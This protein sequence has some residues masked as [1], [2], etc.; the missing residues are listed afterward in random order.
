MSKI[1]LVDVSFIYG[2]GTPFEMVA[3]DNVNVKFEK[4]KITC[5]R[6]KGARQLKIYV[7]R[8]LLIST[9]LFLNAFVRRKGAD[10]Y[11]F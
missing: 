9:I 5:L 10:R 2:K 3:L 4:G 6:Q 1:E 8:I 7:H 11:R